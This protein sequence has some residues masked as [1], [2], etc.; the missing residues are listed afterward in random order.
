MDEYKPYSI[1]IPNDINLVGIAANSIGAYAK[2]VGFNRFDRKKIQYGI[3]ECLYYIIKH[4]YFE[5]EEDTIK[6]EAIDIAEGIKIVVVNHGIPVD[7]KSLLKEKTNIEALKSSKKVKSRLNKTFDRIDYEAKGYEGN[8]CTLFSYY[9]KKI[10]PNVHPV[11]LGMDNHDSPHQELDYECRKMVDDEVGKISRLA[12]IAYHYS[13]PYEDIY[14]PSKIKELKHKGNLISAVA[15]LV[16]NNEIVS[17]SALVLPNEESKFAEIGIAFTDPHFRG[18][19]CVDKLW[20]FLIYKVGTELGLKGIFANTVTSH[21]FSQKAAHAH[22][23]K[24]SAL[25]VSKAPVLE[26]ENLVKDNTQRESLLIS[27]IIDTESLFKIF[28]PKN[29]KAIINDILNHLGINYIHGKRN[30][31]EV[32]KSIFSVDY[33]S[34]F[35]ISEIKIKHISNQTIDEILKVFTRTLTDDYSCMHLYL[36]LEDPLTPKISKVFEEKGFFFAGI[37]PD[38]NQLYLTFQYLNNQEY[39]YELLKIES[40]FGKKLLDYI[41][42]EDPGIHV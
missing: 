12:Y 5:D 2:L 4:A 21:V 30:N 35:N 23:M 27:T 31:T 32:R 29:H 38:E 20:S 19:G 10:H 37:I 1:S 42:D 25:L 28:V 39:R 33:N 26:F 13:Y 6:I 14:I 22:G 34:I 8:I 11:V 18:H 36:N 3:E 40:D 15:S 16:D 17:H 24:D 9:P 7:E 41:V